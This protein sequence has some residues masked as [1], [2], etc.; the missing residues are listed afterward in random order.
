[1]NENADL[2]ALQLCQ[3]DLLRRLDAVC[4]KNGLTYCLAFGSCLGAVRHGGFIPW[5]DDVDVY[6]PAG[7]FERLKAIAGVFP[8]PYFLQ[9][10]ESDPEYGLMIGRLRNSDT[11]LV[12]QGESDRR[13]NHGVFIDIYPLFG[14]P[15]HGFRKKKMV[16][17]SM[18]YR[19]FLYG[20]APK[21][22][23]E[24]YRIG[25]AVLLKLTPKK[26]REAILCRCYRT[27]SSARAANGLCSLY[28]DEAKIVY[29]VEWFFP[30]READ[31]EDLRVF[32]PADCDRYLTATYGDYMKLPPKEK[33]VFHHTYEKIDTENSYKTYFGMQ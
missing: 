23:G 9:T 32:V 1:M 17:A 29:P 33:Q 11:T 4:R 10:L 7:D 12:E 14:C 5:D 30:V 15:D 27:M 18:F 13:I 21:N 22:R 3:L 2:K 19:L 20:R 28:G 16:L 25:S 8:E 6:M 26:C 31:F 24:V